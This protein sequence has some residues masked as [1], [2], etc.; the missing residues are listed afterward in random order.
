V[1]QEIFVTYGDIA[2]PASHGVSQASERPEMVLKSCPKPNERIL[3]LKYSRH[4]TGQELSS[5]ERRR[6]ISALTVTSNEREE[7]IRPGTSLPGDDPKQS[8][9][10]ECHF[11]PLKR[12]KLTSQDIWESVPPV[13]GW[14]S[15]SSGGDVPSCHWY[16][17]GTGPFY[18]E[19]IHH[20]S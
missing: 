8:L 3:V 10:G 17:Y 12:L 20:L 6:L 1:R 2:T 5:K 14:S 7:S 11:R 19:L 13:Q 16:G 9:D 4:S 18:R 15:A